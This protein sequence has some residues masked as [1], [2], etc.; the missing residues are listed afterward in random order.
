[1]S[2]SN[3]SYAPPSTVS[4]DASV[5]QR[6]RNETEHLK[7]Q[8]VDLRETLEAL[9]NRLIGPRPEKPAGGQVPQPNSPGIFL[10]LADRAADTQQWVATCQALVHEMLG[11]TEG[12]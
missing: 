9:R 5:A 6:A 1:M 3:P 4:P 12:A 2:P 10:E 7:K 11:A 8:V